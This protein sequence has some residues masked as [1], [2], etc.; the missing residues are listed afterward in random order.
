MVNGEVLFFALLSHV[1]RLL[2]AAS[3]R[4]NAEG[5]QEVNHDIRLALSMAKDIRFLWRIEGHWRNY[6]VP[7]SP[8]E[9]GSVLAILHAVLKNG[10]TD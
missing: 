7:D 3:E 2:D 5:L 1:D 8:V 4:A 9:P 10:W 6:E